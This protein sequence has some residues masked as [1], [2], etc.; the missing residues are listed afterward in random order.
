MSSSSTIST[1]IS[2]DPSSKSLGH[3]EDSVIP[4]KS[5]I[6]QTF[7]RSKLIWQNLHKRATSMRLQRD[8]ITLSHLIYGLPA[9]P[10]D[11]RGVKDVAG[12]ATWEMMKTRGCD[13]LHRTMTEE[14]RRW[15]LTRR[16]PTLCM[17]SD[18]CHFSYIDTKSNGIALL[19]F[20]WAYILCM[21][22]L[23]KQH[24]PMCYS[25]NNI[26]AI[27]DHDEHHSD[28]QELTVDIGHVSE[29]EFRWWTSLVSPGQGWRS[30]SGKQQPVWA[31]AYTGTIKVRL[32][33]QVLSSTSPNPSPPSSRQAVKFLSR[34]ASMYNLDSQVPL[35]LA[36]ALTLPL[37]NDTASMVKLPRPFLTRQDSRVASL[38]SIEQEYNN[39]SRYMT[40]SSNPVFLSSTLW[41]VF[42]EPGVECNLVSP[43]CDPIIDVVKPLVDGGELEMLGHILA[44][45]RPNVA[46][47]WYGIA[48]CGQTR[49]ILAVVPFLQSLYTPV[50]S[51][52]IPEVAAWTGS[53]QSFMDLR[54]S[55]AYLQAGDQVARADVWRLRHECWD[56][57]SEGAPFRNPPMCPWP[58]FGFM[59]ADELELPVRLHVNCDRHQW[60]YLGWTWLLGNG[61][62]MVKT[63]LPQK[64]SSSLFKAE[65]QVD[66]A[67][68]SVPDLDYSLDHVASERAVGDVFRWVATE[69]EPAGK[70][71]YLH[72]WVDAQADLEMCGNDRTDSNS[73]GSQSSSHSP[74]ERV[75]DWV[76]NTDMECV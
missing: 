24:I 51:R 54:E 61:A 30:A 28:G 43:W 65:L 66:L 2:T 71:I 50:P 23:E 19:F 74:A 62:V 27:P 29:E 1:T 25:S 48:A 63:L 57:E 32:V 13:T 39:L 33:A 55:G 52:P 38:S 64:S 73:G 6:Y 37:H 49:T 3:Q 35:A 9:M 18:H 46:P 68:S 31:I 53:P 34:F 42:W 76:M 4:S 5:Q 45:R 75:E 12:Q 58:P 17:I 15:T 47:L 20:G 26:S 11:L 22:L 16:R 72:P 10:D 41:A 21:T 56:V 8:T 60:V 14:K 44:L 36:M 40:L 67:T 69:M 7:A 70:D 59:K